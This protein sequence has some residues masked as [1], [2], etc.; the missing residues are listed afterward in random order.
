MQ[1]RPAEQVSAQRNHGVFR[2]IQANVTLKTG[3]CVFPLFIV[4]VI[5]VVDDGED[6][7]FG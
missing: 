7:M 4:L 6:G 2:N 1:T 5:V 3:R